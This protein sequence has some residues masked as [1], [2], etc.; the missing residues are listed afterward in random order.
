MCFTAL[1]DEQMIEDDHI[2]D[3]D[4]IQQNENAILGKILLVRAILGLWSRKICPYKVRMFVFF[5]HNNKVKLFDLDARNDAHVQ[6]RQL[7]KLFSP[8]FTDGT[9]KSHKKNW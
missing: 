7:R 4:E 8:L 3:E 5:I 9:L 1:K 6:K 2:P